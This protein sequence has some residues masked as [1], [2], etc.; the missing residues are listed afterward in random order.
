MKAQFKEI[1]THS[2]KEE[3]AKAPRKQVD[4]TKPDKNPKEYVVTK[5]RVDVKVGKEKVIVDPSMK[6]YARTHG[7]DRHGKGSMKNDMSKVKKGQ[8]GKRPA[9]ASCKEGWKGK[10]NKGKS[11]Y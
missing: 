4:M 2:A 11:F 9:K 10:G 1:D 8:N 6:K 3:Q 5:K 7:M